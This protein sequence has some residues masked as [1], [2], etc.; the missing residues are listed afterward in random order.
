[1]TVK[2]TPAATDSAA[3]T[4]AGQIIVL[5]RDL[6]FGVR[7][8][9]TLR[10]LGYTVSFAAD[11][12]GFIKVVRSADPPAV[13]GIIDMN[14]GVDWTAIQGLVH[15]EAT[16]TPVLVFGPHLDIEGRRAAKS[17]GV[18]RLVTNGEFHRDLVGLVRRYAL[19]MPPG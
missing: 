11:T 16:A 13:L 15:D 6:M 14:A 4:K 9:N 1:M 5:N 12:P 7:I 18:T 10:G 19:S 3:E 8:G 2:P 17:A